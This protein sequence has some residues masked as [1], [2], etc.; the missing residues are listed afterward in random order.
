MAKGEQRWTLIIDYLNVSSSGRYLIFCG[1][2]GITNMGNIDQT[3][4][5][6]LLIETQQ[7]LPVWQSNPWQTR[8]SASRGLSLCS[9]R[10]GRTNMTLRYVYTLKPVSEWQKMCSLLVT[11]VCAA[12]GSHGAVK[13]LLWSCRSHRGL[14]HVPQLK[15][16]IFTAD[17]CRKLRRPKSGIQKWPKEPLKSLHLLKQGIKTLFYAGAT[18]L[19][20][21][22]CH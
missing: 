12:P 14:T 9:R 5:N 18:A 3:S 8:A 10:G 13:T 22:S 1:F 20:L 6:M 15:L 17:Y 11:K 7:W 16:W 4:G 19:H 21:L 2:L